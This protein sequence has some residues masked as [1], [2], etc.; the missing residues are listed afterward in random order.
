MILRT[1]SLIKNNLQ[2]TAHYGFTLLEVLL[3]IV[4]MAL[5]ASLVVPTYPSLSQADARIRQLQSLLNWAGNRAVE[6]DRLIGLNV[7]KKGYTLVV[8][9]MGDSVKSPGWHT[10]QSG[11]LASHFDWPDGW[12]VTVEPQGLNQNLTQKPQILFLPDGQITPFNLSVEDNKSV[13]TLRSSGL[14]PVQLLTSGRR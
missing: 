14:L 5:A 6:N 2:L 12:Q 11:R 13:W 7:S 9:N 1:G 8:L 10:Y 3:A 4:L